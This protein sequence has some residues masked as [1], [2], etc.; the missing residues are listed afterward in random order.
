MVHSEPRLH[1]KIIFSIFAG[2]TLWASHGKSVSEK[3]LSK[4][5]FVSSDQMSLKIF[6]EL[7]KNA[8]VLLKC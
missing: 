4:Y 3:K 8:L 7:L 1:G 2:P 5:K 6:A